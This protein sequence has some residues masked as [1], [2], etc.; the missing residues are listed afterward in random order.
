MKVVGQTFGEPTRIYSYIN[1]KSLVSLI[2]KNVKDGKVF[3][4]NPFEFDIAI[5]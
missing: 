1:L 2:N 3:G 5:R 4:D